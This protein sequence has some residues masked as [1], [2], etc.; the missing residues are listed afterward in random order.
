MKL[1]QGDW[2]AVRVA[3]NRG[4]MDLAKHVLDRI[5]LA[6]TVDGP[7]LREVLEEVC[8]PSREQS[9][10]SNVDLRLVVPDYVQHRCQHAHDD[11]DYKT[12]NEAELDT[13]NVM[14]LR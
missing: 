2:R 12:S 14:W 3:Y 6:S 9:N 10:S 13:P 7:T 11:A 1:T 5:E 8:P 4:A